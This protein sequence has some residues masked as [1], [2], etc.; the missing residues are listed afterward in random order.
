M[1]TRCHHLKSIAPCLHLGASCFQL[2]IRRAELVAELIRTAGFC[3][4]SSLIS[5]SLEELYSEDADWNRLLPDLSYEA[6]RPQVRL[7][8]FVG[9]LQSSIPTGE[10]EIL[11]AATIQPKT[12][13]VIYQAERFRPDASLA[14]S[15]SKLKS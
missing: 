10:T 14:F 12:S 6:I 3:A 15:P 7:S 9:G 5:G 2:F 8:E 13:T 11:T 1:E 4:P